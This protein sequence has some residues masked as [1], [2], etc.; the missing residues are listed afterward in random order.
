MVPLSG[1]DGMNEEVEFW[2]VVSELVE[3]ETPLGPP[4]S[5]EVRTPPGG[6]GYFAVF[7]TFEA[8]V[9][10]ASDPTKIKKLRVTRPVPP[11]GQAEETP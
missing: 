3:F 9:G 8:A 5:V 7:D 11:R 4:F 10:F 6:I 2:W 1:A